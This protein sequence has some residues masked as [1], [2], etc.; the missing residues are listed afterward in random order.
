[1]LALACSG[2]YDRFMHDTWTSRGGIARAKKL[3][4]SRRSSIARQAARARWKRRQDGILSVS[5]IRGMVERAIID[6][7]GTLDGTSAFLFGSYARGLARPDSD[8]DLMIVEK[9]VPDDWAHETTVLRD[10]MT[11]DKEIDLIVMDEHDF[12]YWKDQGGTVQHE[13]AQKGIRLV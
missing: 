6:R 3:S 11:F 13:V 2:M 4:P 8:I 5:Q 12:N 10:R 9:H 1:M 7:L